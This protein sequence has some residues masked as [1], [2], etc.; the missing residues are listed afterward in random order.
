MSETYRMGLDVG[1][2]TIKVVVLDQNDQ[3]LFSDYRR[4]RS[5][6]QQS[7]SALFKDIADALGDFKAHVSV[8]GSGGMLAA[9]WLKIPFIQEV[10]AGTRAVEEK[11]PETDC[12]IELGGEDA[13]ITF[14]GASVEQ[15]M[16][17]TCAGGTGAFIDQMAS[18]LKTDAG[19]LNELA[20]HHTTIYPIASRCG[21][22]AKTDIQ[23]LI[24]DGAERADIA[25][26]VFQAV[27]NQTISGLACGHTISGHVAFLGGPLYFL[28]ELRQRF[29]ETL[30]L[31]PEEVEFP[32]HSNLFVAL[33]TAYASE[34][35]PVVSFSEL[36]SRMDKPFTDEIGLGHL[37]PLFKDQT[38]LDEFMARHNRDKVK[39]GQLTAYKG[40]VFLGIDAG[41]TTTK[42]AV[43]GKDGEL[44]YSFYSSN[45]GSP[46]KKAI[47]ILKDIYRKLPEGAYI[48]NAASTGY[49]EGLIKSALK[50]DIGEVETM[51]H[52]KGASYF[53]PDVDF[54]LDIGGQDMKA[55]RIRSGAIDSIIL[56]EACSSGCGS[57]LETFAKSLNL[58]ISQFVEEALTAK[59]PSNLGTRCTVFMNSKV[60]QA[61]KENATVGD[62]SAGLSYSVIKNALQKVIK[63]HNPKELGKNIVV[64]GGTFNNNAV[65]R[66]FE[67]ITGRD[68][69]RPDVAGLMG[70]FGAALIAKERWHEGTEST[71]L[72]LEDLDTFTTT[73]KHRRCG[74]CSNNCQL[75]INIFED[76]SRH[77]TGNRCEIGAGGVR[78]KDHMPNLYQYKYKRLFDYEPLPED[79]APRGTIGIPRAL[80]QYEN[81]PFWFTF[82]T[83]LGYRVVLSSKST[84][85]IYEKGMSSIPSESVCYPAKLTHGHIQDLIDKGVKKIWYPCVAYEEKEFD[86]ADNCFNCPIVMSYPETIKY[87][88]D[89]LKDAHVKFMNPFLA[90]DNHKRLEEHL[91]EVFADEG[92]SA[93]EVSEAL[94]K[95]YVEKYQVIG[96]LLQKGK[97]TVQWLR[98]NHKKGIVL[99]GRPYHVDP[100]I[101]HGLDNVITSLGMA[102]LTEDSVAELASSKSE[103][104]LRV[105]D[106]WKYH[107][108]LYRAAEFVADHD[109]LALVQ[110]T[111]F[112]CG[113]D[114][115]TSDQTQEILEH[116]GKIYTLIKID[117][118]SNLGAIRIRL[119]SLKA[120]LLERDA[121][122]I[123]V[124]GKTL[125]KKVPFTKE[126]RK[127]H[128]VL[129]PQMSP[130][131]FDLFSTAM[132]ASGYNFEVLPA[133]DQKAVDAGLSYV[134]NDAC[135]P[136][137]L[138]VGQIMAALKSGKYDLNNVS[139]IMSQTGGPCR[140][141]NYVGFIR[142]ALKE[143]GMEQ[144]PVVSI[145]TVGLE[146]NPGFK[147]TPNMAHRIIVAAVYG[148]LFQR[149]LYATRPYE[150][151]PGSANALYEKW[152]EKVRSNIIH[153]F[154]RT[155]KKN[156]RDI[157]REFDELPRVDKTIPKVGIVGEILVKYHPTANNNLVK[158]LEKEG[159]QVVSPDIIDFFLYC[160][161]N[162]IYKHDV[163]SGTAKAK[164]ANE[165]AIK[166]VEHY[167]KNMK[168]ALNESRHFSAPSTI[169]K[170][171]KKAT[172][173]ISLGNQ[174]GEGWFLTSEMMELI[175]SG[176]EN[177]VCVQPFAC[178]PNHVMGKG[179]IKP[180]R[181]RYPYANIAPID[182]DPGASEVNQINR[183]KLMVDTAW[184]NLEKKERGKKAEA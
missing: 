114:A 83:S 110:L 47:E 34:K 66:A 109:E 75:T 12:A 103:Q 124:P 42:A 136:S 7:M 167:R 61:Q 168:Q 54:I 45:E 59:R 38:E 134:N 32:E 33:G 74:G 177:I 80:N 93:E 143:A 18:L 166:V 98:R 90:L 5:N 181:R 50:V 25:A 176:V 85:K 62:I 28:S 52:F 76:G 56:N 115:V 8:T 55:M 57:F 105:L 19:G 36:I 68:V 182:Y 35:Q 133:V 139:V 174:A 82:L 180:I 151:V 163:L 26:S 81:Y 15:R 11:I 23:P 69:I 140:A 13:K 79:Q 104:P 147:I 141:S 101:N 107:S 97:E 161:Y 119:R 65:L 20:K 29:I 14:F 17:G 102:V 135:Y 175:E 170:K 116:K 120:A 41:S 165:L 145:N 87:N 179:M 158:V 78:N 164:T 24:N 60:K 148:D 169:Q 156:V 159:C 100:E 53:K 127:K 1:S 92:V 154:G 89:S 31:K 70:A 146:D 58:P 9:N 113:L 144:V 106:Q 10:V 51:A 132:N 184:K 178:L 77:V 71:V 27:V 153:P 49:G 130:I 111:S 160:S 4:H 84:R 99:A 157:V 40:P 142:K 149:V 117:E 172:E 72:K 39:R 173:L 118:V 152:R 94:K 21:V 88:M 46:L 43:I 137:I 2:T 16:N 91:T 122:H 22:F 112:G 30:K 63:V 37:D 162:A 155:F 150:K 129:C 96:D 44:L 183:I 86:S 67:K 48:A 125:T 171:A 128:T 126:M 95:A 108:R 3:I 138:T 131:H 121:H 123:K 6:I 64:Q 73:V